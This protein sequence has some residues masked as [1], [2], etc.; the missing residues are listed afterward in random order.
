MW[1]VTIL[2]LGFATVVWSG[3]IPLVDERNAVTVRQE[4]SSGYRLPNST[5]PLKYN[6][7]LT[8]HIHDHN[9]PSQFEFDGKVIISL[10][11]QEQNVRNITLHYRRII[12]SHVKL[13]E[14]AEIGGS[15]IINDDSSFVTDE[16]YEFLVIQAPSVLKLGVYT[17]EIQYRGELRS[18]NGGFYRSSYLD[19][20]GNTRWIAT[21]QFESTDARHAFPCYDE[22]RFRAP[23]GLKLIHGNTYHAISNMDIQSQGNRDVNYTITEFKD[24][25]SMQTYL[26]AFVVSDFDYISDSVNNQSV[27]AIPAAI[28]NGDLNFALEAGV[29]I[30]KA[31]E[32]YL[33]VKYSF[34]KLDQIGIP[35]FAAGAMENWGLVTYREEALLYNAT[36]S[37]MS[38]LK[39]TAAI[40]AHE[41]GHQFFGNLV[42]P[43]WWSYLWLNEGFATLFEYLA[44]DKAYPELRVQEMFNIEAL[45]VAFQS[46]A[47]ETTRAMNHYVETPAAIAGLFD[48]IAYQK[49]GSVLRQLQ[50]AFGDSVFRAGLK[51]YLD[52]KQLQSA[53][54]ADLATGLQRS[55]EEAQAI[56]SGV[57]VID[58]ISSWADQKG[59]PLLHVSRDEKSV[60][61]IR[62]ERYL[63][64]ASK[65]N[66][67]ATWY[68]PYNLATYQTADFTST[69]PLD[70]LTTESAEIRPTPSLNWDN[71]DWV[72]FNKKQTGYYRVN[73][74][75]RLW[76]LIIKNLHDEEYESIHHLNRAQLIDDSLNLA[77]SGHLKYDIALEL[78]QYLS[79]ETEYIPWASANNG[80]SYLN[81]MLTGSSKYSL[82]K[83]YIWSLVEPSFK[84]LGM[85]SDP[86]ESLFEK[87]TRNIIINWACT[88]ESADCLA[89]TR[90]Q[91]GE[92][93]SNKTENVE[94][95]LRSV[96]FCNG[97]RNADRDTFLFVWD[98]M[99]RSQ[100]P[101]ERTLLMNAL[102]CSQNAELLR[103]YLDTSLDESSDTNYRDQER[104]RV[105]SAVY[106]NGQV[107]LE[108]SM[109][110]L[111]VNAK[112]IDRLYNG[113]SFG[114]RAIGSAVTGMAKRIVNKEQNQEFVKLVTKLAAGNYLNDGEIAAAK[115]LADE[116]I[117]WTSKNYGAIESW[118]EDNMNS[119]TA[120]IRSAPVAI[121]LCC[122]L[123]AFIY[124]NIL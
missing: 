110:F 65:G 64:K 67:N 121:T 29:K 124:N 85:T 91:L 89:Q 72:I 19:S 75:D 51:L 21:T 57:K 37:P 87:L 103:L 112:Q 92:V 44:S 77:R 120:Q 105:F 50:H 13:S 52:N 34:P 42:S 60:I 62:Q 76:D 3:H 106:S 49:A 4:T 12:L 97:L 54:P 45:Q 24:T 107:G 5:L 122:T 94:P 47:L 46:D 99:Q 88:V 38:Q 43:A 22:P 30:I 78:N 71:N 7:E 119:G 32:D 25:L 96:V 100:D 116:N 14:S 73:Y 63:L 118:L 23:I 80:L 1:K 117:V 86:S 98:R 82:F 102:G 68:I 84:K 55:V 115:E 26:L 81:R 20:R 27:Y 123:V 33:Q 56:P 39:R 18:D 108:T 101:S 6:I 95:N 74:D 90:A 69:L 83:K 53:T 93:V 8:T 61:K 70:W 114:G 79:K 15:V 17:L 48:D 35:D 10:R 59:Y 111:D 9:S 16:T 109:K 40:I 2:V 36:K 31:L 28:A 104:S 11:V 58:I 113:G 66:T 41:Y